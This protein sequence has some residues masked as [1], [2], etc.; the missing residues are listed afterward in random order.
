VRAEYERFNAAGGNPSLLSAGLFQKFTE[1]HVCLLKLHPVFKNANY[2]GM[3]AD[4]S[5]LA[6]CGPNPAGQ[7]VGSVPLSPHSR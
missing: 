7:A 5:K 6:R 1:A 3:V 4:P 2:W